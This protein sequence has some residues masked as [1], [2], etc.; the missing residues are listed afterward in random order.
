MLNGT[1]AEAVQEMLLTT[2]EN[3]SQEKS[4]KFSGELQCILNEKALLDFLFSFY[5]LDGRERPL[6]HSRRF[7]PWERYILCDSKVYEWIFP[8]AEDAEGVEQQ[9]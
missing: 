1:K 3:R 4:S 5:T 8:L 7:L 9:D 2:I 6:D